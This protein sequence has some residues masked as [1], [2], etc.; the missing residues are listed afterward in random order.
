M[1]ITTTMHVVVAHP[2]LSISEARSFLVEN[3]GPLYASHLLCD[4]G[5]D[6]RVVGTICIKTLRSEGWK[7]M[8]L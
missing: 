3:W 7:I 6:P 1:T 8:P 4:K 2:F 5:F